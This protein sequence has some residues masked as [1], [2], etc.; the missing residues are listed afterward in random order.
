MLITRAPEQIASW[1]VCFWTYANHWLARRIP[2]RFKHVSALG[3]SFGGHSWVYLDCSVDRFEVHVIPSN[4]DEG[5]QYLGR[6][7]MDAD[8][9]L[10]VPGD[11]RMARPPRFG[12]FCVPFVRRVVGVPGSAL[13]PDGF[14][15]DCM[16]AGAEIV[17]DNAI[18]RAVPTTA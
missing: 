8:L 14:R 15:Q 6:L 3:R 7:T 16:R 13:L 2:G 4:N 9:V 18:R 1:Q 10:R 12:L 17:I 5:R 11:G